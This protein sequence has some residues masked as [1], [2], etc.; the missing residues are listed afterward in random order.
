[1][2]IVRAKSGIREVD[3]AGTI[4]PRPLVQPRRRD[5]VQRLAHR[6]QRPLLGRVFDRPRL[7]PIEAASQQVL[8]GPVV[9]DGMPPGPLSFEYPAL[10]PTRISSPHDQMPWFAGQ[11]PKR[12]GS[13]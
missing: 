1:M 6:N 3:A 10:N 9:I 8:F 11:P 2:R 4:L 13:A 12:P 7:A 5:A